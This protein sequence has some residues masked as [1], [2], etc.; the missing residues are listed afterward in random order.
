MKKSIFN[1][2]LNAIVLTLCVIVLTAC[3]ESAPTEPV[4]VE[5]TSYIIALDLSDR[6]ADPQTCQ[7]DINAVQKVFEQFEY[8]VAKEHRYVK[9]EDCFLVTLVPQSSSGRVMNAQV[10]ALCIDLKTIPVHD[11]R[12]ALQDFKAAL[13]DRLAQL[14]ASATAKGSYSGA[15][16]YAYF[17]RVLPELLAATT[18]SS[19]LFTLITDG[20]LELDDPKETVQREGKTN[21]MNR[22]LMA[23]LRQG[24]AYKGNSDVLLLPERLMGREGLEKL[25]VLLLG[26]KAKANYIDELSLLES[27]WGSWFQGMKL[28]DARMV[29]YDESVLVTDQAIT[30]ALQQI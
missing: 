5:P 16:I 12:Q 4:A 17:D 7:Q 30:H 13:P 9:A 29:P 22:Q 14:Y 25:H 15:N 3:E 28:K 11:R 8:T 23:R 27:V 20:Y 6:I 26:L 1:R 21:Y 24:D 10:D 18:G 19:V 2:M